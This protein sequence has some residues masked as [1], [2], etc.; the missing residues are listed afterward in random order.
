MT[1]IV[2]SKFR[3]HNSQQFI[4]GFAEAAPTNMYLFIG[5]PQ[6]WTTDTS[7][8]TPSDGIESEYSIWD[9]MIALKRIQSSDIKNA[10]IRRSWT[11]GV[12]YDEY[13][14]NYSSTSLS[15]SGASQLYSATFFVVTDD[16]NIYKC[17]F[18]NNNVASTVKPTGTSTSIITT[19]DGYKWKFMYTISPG[20]ALKFVTTD[21]LPVATNSTVASA[22]VDGAIHV[23][24]VTNGGSGYTSAT[25]VITGSGSGATAVVV[26]SSGQV[27]AVN[28]TAPGINFRHATVTISGDGTSA[29]AL[30]IIEPQGG[31]G[32]DAV[33]ELGGF[34]AMMNTRLEYADG[35][36]DFP[37]TNDY[38]RIGI[39]RDPYDFGTTTVSTASTLR[40]NKTITLSAGVTGT[41]VVDEL[42]TGGT[43]VAIGRV[44]DWDATNRV[45]RFYQSTSENFKAFQTGETITGGTSG[46][47]GTSSALGNSEVQRDTGDIIYVE[48]RRPITRASDQVESISLVIE[49]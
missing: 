6:P 41:F 25:A 10:I 19:G 44:V 48:Q 23:I 17:V 9:D 4:E 39:V 47:V 46:A 30:G 43:S 7:P 35:T 2:T 3:I 34:Y 5:R 27:T 11:T 36:G 14:H 45:V 21:F 33:E 28:I 24:K 20:D 32:A 8:P 15:N 29:T 49:F 26:V 16:Y 31:H 38:R 13:R 18:N 22:A 40:A 37:V 42:V 12:I 1:A